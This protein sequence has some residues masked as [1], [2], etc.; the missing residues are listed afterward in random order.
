MKAM[1]ITA[2][3]G[4]EV[5]E[6][7]ELPKPEPGIG[8]LLIKVH[9]SSINPVDYKIRMNGSWAVTPP[10]IIGYDASGVVEKC[11]PGV[12]DFKPG[13]EVFYT[14]FIEQG[15]GT[16]AQYAVVHEDIVA[17]KP[18]NMSFLEAAGMP[19]AGC[20]ALDAIVNLAK[21]KPGENVLVHAG[22]G[23][24]GSFAIQLAKISGAI[25]ATTCSPKNVD[26]VKS[27]G[28]DIAIDYRKE[29]FTKAFFRETGGELADVVF[30]TVGGDTT[31]RSIEITKKYGRIVSIVNVSGNINAGHRKNITL[32]LLFLERAKHKIEMMRTLSE[33][34]KIKTVVDSV[35]PLNK[36][37][38][39]HQKLENGG[40]RGKIILQVSA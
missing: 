21:V 5:F 18:K 39:A 8:E 31:A 7:K 38:E 16:Y 6:E 26:L 10:A 28:A 3:G 23:G 34:G 2:F 27:L 1:V 14:P 22:A 25:V 30:D 37:S 35:F 4:P 29:D 12:K 19:L 13:D 24:V 20:T 17:L 11:G 36:V 32:Y 15:H 40:V 33:E 9:A